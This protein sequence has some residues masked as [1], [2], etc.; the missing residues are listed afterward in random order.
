[1]KAQTI[2]PVVVAALTVVTLWLHFGPTSTPT[3]SAAQVTVLVGDNW[4]C[5]PTFQNGVC[6]TEVAVG[7]TVLWDFSAAGTNHT[8]T[9]GCTLCAA[10]SLPPL[11]DSGV[12][13]PGGTFAFTF[14]QPGMYPYDSTLQPLEMRGVIVV[15]SGP[16]GGIAELPEVAGTPLEAPGSSRSTSAGLLA[17][18]AAA[19]A[20]GTVTLSG[21]AW[22][23]RRRWG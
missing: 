5:D 12:V 19:V 22:Y 18:I 3:A 16:V 21:A 13:D 7:G 6:T 17:S 4:F 11:W 8:T 1:M 9:E 10:P 15:Q 2:T 20:A 23:A 14:S